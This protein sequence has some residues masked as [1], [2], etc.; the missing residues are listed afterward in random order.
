MS[1]VYRIA[2][3]SEGKWLFQVFSVQ[4]SFSKY[5]DVILQAEYLCR[6]ITVYLLRRSQLVS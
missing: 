6:N 2:V 3:L 5:F 1:L 4:K